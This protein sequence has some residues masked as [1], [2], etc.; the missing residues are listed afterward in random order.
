MPSINKTPNY[1][2]SQ[3]QANEYPKRQDFVDDN[4]SID[5]AIKARADEIAN[6]KSDTVAHMTQVQKDQLAATVPKTRKI[7]GKA[8]NSDVNLT[9]SDV[10]AAPL[11]HVSD[12]VAHMTQAQKDQLA[13]AVP[14]SRKVNG[15]ALSADINLTSSDTGSIPISQKGTSGGVANYDD[16]AAH[17]SNAGIHVTAAQ[18]TAWTAKAEKTDIPTSLPAN[19]GTAAKVSNAL[20]ISQ[21]YGGQTGTYDGSAAK[22]ISVPKVTISDAEPTDTLTDG[23]LWGV[24][25]TS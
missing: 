24:Y 16:L 12:T 10:D 3:W 2:L 13:A 11:S 19:G 25:S 8:L 14:T 4:A 6:H 1:G 15:K 21:G 23:E 22:S 18:K 5:A 7:N 17:T 9:S 20:S